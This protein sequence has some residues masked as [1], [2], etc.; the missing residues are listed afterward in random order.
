MT[1][2]FT[3]LN[4][5]WKDDRLMVGRRWSGARIVPDLVWTKMFRVE[6]PAG[7]LSDMV[8]KTRAKDAAA[9]LVL[10]DLNR[11]ETPSGACQS[12]FDGGGGQLP[13]EEGNN[14][15]GGLPGGKP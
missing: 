13:T 1:R 4:L 10:G 9:S 12:D 5:N 3:R 14:A 2:V 8:N 11:Q 7:K 6:Y 15:S